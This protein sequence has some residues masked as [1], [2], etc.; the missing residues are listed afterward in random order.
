[1]AITTP[2][3]ISIPNARDPRKG[4]SR[5]SGVKGKCTINRIK[6]NYHQ[7]KNQTLH[8]ALTLYSF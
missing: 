2:T 6:V 5:S 1:M 4:L 3:A 8:I 7:Y